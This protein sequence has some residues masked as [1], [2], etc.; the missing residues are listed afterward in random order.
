MNNPLMTWWERANKVPGGRFLFNL[1]LRLV[2]PYTG[3]VKGRVVALRPGYARVTMR[4]RR[5]VRNHLRSIHAVAQMNLG[6]FV[7]G[8]AMTARFT[9]EARGIIT[10]LSIEFVKKARGT[11]SAECSC[12]EIDT[13]ESKTYQVTSILKDS[14]GDVVSKATA[15]WLIGPK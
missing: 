13:R 14:S 7:S 11:L 4:D 3:T 6:E 5:K 1:V 15:H 12:D 9:R 2:V 10:G 8:L